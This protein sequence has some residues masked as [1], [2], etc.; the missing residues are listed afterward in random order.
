MPGAARVA[1]RSIARDLSGEGQGSVR[2]G[3]ERYPIGR[4]ATKNILNGGD[5]TMG[6]TRATTLHI[7]LEA[8]STVHRCFR[9]YE[10]DVSADLF[11]AWLV[12]MSYGRIG[13][14]G[15]SKIRSFAAIEGA[16][17]QVQACL[18]RRATAP[19]RIG[20][21]YRVRGRIRCEQWCQRDLD[22]KPQLA[23]VS[24]TGRKHKA[25]RSVRRGDR[26]G[27]DT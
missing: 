24:D 6:Q 4:N 16:Q 3:C 23:G 17:A 9:A 20:V 15:R 19:R 14:T 21:P 22:G 11:G 5:P 27:Y 25:R 13:T 1:S 8:R 10:I 2:G 7:R 26:R 12:E 18:R